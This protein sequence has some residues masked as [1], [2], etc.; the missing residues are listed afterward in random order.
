MA[1]NRRILTKLA[2]ELQATR[3][4]M[5]SQL[6]GVYRGYTYVVK[7]G[8]GSGKKMMMVA[9][10][11][12]ND[13]TPASVDV[14]GTMRAV[15]PSG[16]RIIPKGFSIAVYVPVRGGTKKNVQLIKNLI[17]G[18]ITQFERYQYY[19]CDARGVQG[20]TNV[21]QV[22][23]GYS[24]LNEESAKMTEYA[25]KL[26]QEEDYVVRENYALGLLGAIGGGVLGALLIFLIAR[27]G[28]VSSYAGLAMGAAVIYGYK[29]KGEK[30]STISFLLCVAVS[31][32]WLYLAFRVDMAMVIQA[33]EL[34]DHYYRA[35]SFQSC[36]VHAKELMR[37][38]G[39]MDIYYESLIKMMAFGM[40][41]VLAFGFTEIQGQRKKYKMKKM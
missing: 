17:E 8:T 31:A 37:W 19:N 25:L 12:S 24:F 10:S 11:V 1:S 29:W 39:N 41:G 32:A 33:S 6:H 36:F 21:Y 26:N 3:T 30:L 35:S 40:V 18:M 2:G 16:G 34:S 27:I 38:S 14:W 5:G 7:P 13:Q 22:E 9:F 28:F 23:N 4:G 20:P 15:L